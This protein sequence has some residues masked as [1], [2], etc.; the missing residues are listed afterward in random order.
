MKRACL[1]ILVVSLIPLAGL[2]GCTHS[3]PKPSIAVAEQNMVGAC[4]FLEMVVEISDMGKV[5]LHP[6]HTYD[7]QERVI[8]RAVKLGATHIVWLH[9]YPQGSA[10]RA[11]QCPQ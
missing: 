10:A 8:H 3:R 11:Y 1:I 6:K 5:Q 7:A 9:N 4:E 2:A